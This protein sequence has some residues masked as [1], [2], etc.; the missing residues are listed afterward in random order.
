MSKPI[1]VIAQEWDIRP[2]AQRMQF[3]PG[4]MIIKI[5]TPE[6]L[7][8]YRD[9]DIFLVGDY[10]KD[11]RW[12]QNKTLGKFMQGRNIRMLQDIES[13]PTKPRA[14]IFGRKH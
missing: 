12:I 13:Q 5:N 1:L 9:V 3:P 2:W 10:W 6:A 8:K 11:L 4:G 7:L 14:M